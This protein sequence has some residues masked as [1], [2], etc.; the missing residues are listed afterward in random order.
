MV[1]EDL[2]EGAAS[3]GAA[4]LKTPAPAPHTTKSYSKATTLSPSQGPAFATSTSAAP[5]GVPPTAGTFIADANTGRQ[6][7][8]RTDEARLLSPRHHFLIR[9]KNRRGGSNVN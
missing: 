1:L 9:G 2:G 6:R 4:L 8:T 3:R 5:C 7:V